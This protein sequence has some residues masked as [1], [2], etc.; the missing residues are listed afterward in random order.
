M[1]PT[2]IALFKSFC[3]GKII[4]HLVASL[5]NI[6]RWSIRLFEVSRLY[7]W[8]WIFFYKRAQ[9]NPIFTIGHEYWSCVVNLLYLDHKCCP[10]LVSWLSNFIKDFFFIKE[11]KTTQFLQ[12]DMNIG[13]VLSISCTLIINVAPTWF[14]GS[15]ISLKTWY[16]RAQNNPILAWQWI[17]HGCGHFRDAKVCI[18]I[19]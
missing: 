10:Y 14:H 1:T 16:N 17:I 6:I 12:L 3:E 19:I 8:T 5:C 7:H 11:L 18:I 13:L 9:N 15:L 2:S 4:T